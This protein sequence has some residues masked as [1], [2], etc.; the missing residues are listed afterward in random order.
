MMDSYSLF[1]IYLTSNDQVL[2]VLSV[3]SSLSLDYAARGIAHQDMHAYFYG[4]IAAVQCSR[5]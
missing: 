3:L 4:V 5:Q 1:G 2:F